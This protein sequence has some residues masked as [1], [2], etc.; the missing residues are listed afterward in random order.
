MKYLIS[1]ITSA[2]KNDTFVDRSGIYFLTVTTTKT[3]ILFTEHFH[4]VETLN[5]Y[6]VANY[7][8]VAERKVDRMEKYNIQTLKDFL[9]ANDYDFFALWVMNIDKIMR[10][11]DYKP[12]EAVNYQ[13][14][15][16]RRKLY[17]I[18]NDLEFKKFPL[19]TRRKNPH[20]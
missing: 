7:F 8:D 3:P 16:P 15:I 20:F 19:L 9:V 4:F 2:H 18:I 12:S 14:D 17:D 11:M 6:E 10:F 1:K 13:L 5:A